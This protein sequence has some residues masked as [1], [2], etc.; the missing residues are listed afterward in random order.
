MVRTTKFAGRRIVL[1][2]TVGVGAIALI[3]ALAVAGA[4][5]STPGQRTVP[6]SAQI[7]ASRLQSLP[8]QAQSVISSVLGAAAPRFD[9]RRSATGWTLSGG[10]L[11]ATLTRGQ[12]SFRDA[13]AALSMRLAGIGRGERLTADAPTAVV[14]RANRVTVDRG[15]V[16]EW[17]AAGPLGIEQGFTLERRPVGQAARLTLA[18]ALNGSP[19]AQESAD[20]VRFV[21]PAGRTVLRYGGLDAVDASGRQLHSRLAISDGRL[22]VHV[23]D[24]GARYP[25]TIDPLVQQSDKLVPSDVQTN[26]SGSQF[27]DSVALSSDGNTALIGAQ[28]DNS[29]KGAAWIFTRAGST[30]SQSGPKI[31]PT[32]ETGDGEFGTSVA[33]SRDGMTALIGGQ[34]DNSSTGA[35]WVYTRSGSTWTEQQKLLGGSENG[36]GRFGTSVALSPDGSTA[37]IGAPDDNGGIGAFW[38]F[39]RSGSTWSAQATHFVPDVGPPNNFSEVGTAVALSQTGSTALIGGP[40]DGPGSGA[41]WAYTRSGATWTEQQKLTANDETGPTPLSEFGSAVALSYDGNTALIGGPDDGVGLGAAWAFTRS[42][43]TWNQQGSK[44]LPT[45]GGGRFGNSAALSSDGNTALIGSAGDSN[46]VGAAYLFTRSGAAWTQQQRLTGAG[47]IGFGSFGSGVALASDGQTAMVG[48]FEDNSETGAA[49]PFAP[50]K[51]VCSNV[52]TTAPQGGGAVAVSLSCS[53]PAGANPAFSI[54]SGPSNGTISGLNGT[55]GSL[56][57]TSRPFFSG[58]DSFTY[59]VSDQWGLSNTATASVLVPALPVPRCANVSVRGAKTAT[60]VTV[61]LKCSA[62]IGHGFSYVIVSQPGNG[63]LGPITQ[64]TGRVTYTTHV[65]FSG[66]DRFVYE[67]I[68][69]GGFSAP[70]T[71][72]IAI[73]KLAKITSTMIWQFQPTLR[74]ATVVRQL[75]VNAV[76]GAATVKLACTTRGCPLKARSQRLAKQRVCKGKGKKRKCRRIRPTS[77]TI[78]LSKFVAGAHVKVGTLIK[79]SIVEAD[80]IGKQYVFKIRANRQPAVKITALAPGSTKPCPE[81]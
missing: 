35:A 80:T 26:G 5:G 46:N 65:G 19:R 53:L 77:G 1:G 67:A 9:A 6:V 57:Y 51:P 68:D 78:D 49:F 13:A 76:P 29:S 42:G 12:I 81:C 39:A 72:T 52:A 61:T 43:T 3:G 22:L 73:P 38:V 37:L 79:V 59:R 44:L 54:V 31:V 17:Y 58:Q 14:A 50:P 21:T 25:I 55:T 75:T 69:A 15:G 33:L 32:D 7:G 20:G 2:A 66:T 34:L 11:T 74:T 23:E 60:R 41:A 8:S 16:R 70:A 48:A 24:V 30:W 63:K 56:I 28:I 18:L 64:S 36:P 4:G 45:N 47:E 40:Q 27:G 10:G 62:P 71:A